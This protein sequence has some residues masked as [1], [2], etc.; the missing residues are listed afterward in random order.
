MKTLHI[1]LAGLILIM[2]IGAMAENKPSRQAIIQ[3]YKVS[4]KYQIDVQ[5]MF[6]ILYVENQTFSE[7]VIK[8]NKNKTIDYG[9]F[10]INSVHWSTTC[11]GINIMKLQG[12]VE[13]AAKLIKMHS[14]FKGK[15]KA[16]LAR[17]H[18]KTKSLKT[19]YNFKLHLVPI[20]YLASFDTR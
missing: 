20:R 13:C 7:T 15:D 12:N 17:Y 4:N 3:I 8:V 1:I 16:W 10:Q 2:S 11:K 19:E 5:D 9:L 18:S 14:H 6:K